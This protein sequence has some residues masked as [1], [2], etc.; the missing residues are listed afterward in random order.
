MLILYLGG[1]IPGRESKMRGKIRQ[2][3]MQRAQS[4]VLL[5]WLLLHNSLQDIKPVSWQMC[6]LDHVECLQ[7]GYAGKPYLEIAHLKEE[8]REHLLTG[9]FPP[10]VSH[11]TTFFPR[12]WICL[13]FW[14][15]PPSLLSCHFRNM[16]LYSRES[17]SVWR[18]QRL[19]MVDLG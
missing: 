11:Y 7:T 3:R 16:V 5:C 18:S 6:P 14:F 17:R 12:K 9:S 8:G 10:L 13:P 15:V 2:G 1:T 4:N 19:Q